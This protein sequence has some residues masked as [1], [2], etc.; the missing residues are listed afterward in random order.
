MQKP[1]RQVQLATAPHACPQLAL[2]CTHCLTFQDAVEVAKAEA[3]AAGAF[4]S[5][6]S[7]YVQNGANLGPPPA[8]SEWRKVY[9]RVPARFSVGAKLLQPYPGEFE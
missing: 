6:T 9:V 2:I 8:G 7:R 3:T 5:S 4:G 1:Q